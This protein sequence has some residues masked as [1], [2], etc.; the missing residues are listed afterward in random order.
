MSCYIFTIDTTVWE[1]QPTK[2][3]P[4]TNSEGSFSDLTMIYYETEPNKTTVTISWGSY[5]SSLTD[6]IVFNESLSYYNNPSFHIE[7]PISNIIETFTR[8]QIT[9]MGYTSNQ[10]KEAGFQINELSNV[11]P[12]NKFVKSGYTC[13]EI[14][15]SGYEIQSKYKN[16]LLIDTKVKDYHVFVE[17]SNDDTLPI[18]YNE[19][20]SRDEL[21]GV[22]KN[23]IEI[24]R[25]GIVFE[26]LSTYTFLNGED[27]FNSSNR[28]FL[29]DIIHQYKIKNIDFLACETLLQDE[30]KE[31]YNDLREKT[32]VIVGAS[33]NK[34]GNIQYGGDW[35]M[36]STSTDI[37]LIFFNKSIEYYK[38]LLGYNDYKLSKSNEYYSG[39][40]IFNIYK[41]G[42]IY[43]GG[44]DPIGYDN[45]VIFLTNTF[46]PRGKTVKQISYARG[47]IMILM[48]DGTIYGCGG[49]DYG[50]FG[51]G[52]RTTIRIFTLISQSTGKTISQISCNEWNTFLL[53]TDGTIYG[54]GYNDYGQLGDGT[55]NSSVSFTLML[56]STGKIPESV[57]FCSS[58]YIL[59]LM[60]DGTIYGCGDNYYF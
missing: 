51:N 44:I 29:I 12:E 31:F 21:A 56:N 11:F 20:T 28:E 26:K 14:Y 30:W 41:N 58:T 55:T 46:I 5:I 45:N 16:I 42:K 36:E 50:Q 48:T 40:S 60:T 59:V 34:T 43:I 17:S 24:E 54:S 25:V 1:S 22:L 49:N 10:L 35:V 57:I 37:E 33:N 15:Q 38:Y 2:A 27:I 39:S 7:T 53:M 6:G 47:F 52:S 8:E 9:K 3:Y 4:V 23:Q 32:G 18:I 19:T 13:S